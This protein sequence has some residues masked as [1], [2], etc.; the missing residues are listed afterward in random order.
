HRLARHRRQE[1]QAAGGEGHGGAPAPGERAVDRRGGQPGRAHQ[2]GLTL[3]PLQGQ[4]AGLHDHGRMTGPS[5]AI[6]HERFPEYGGSE[7]VVE[8]LHALWPDAPI[9]AAVVD[10]A[11]VPPGL[12]G[13]DIRPTRL[14]RLYRGG[15]AYSHLLP[16]IPRAMASLDLGGADLVVTSHHAFANRVRPR[17]GTPVISYTHTPARWLWEPSMRTSEVGGRAGTA[18]LGAF[19]ASQRRADAAAAARLRGVV[20][21]SH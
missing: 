6:V 1:Q 17:P 14:Q 16:F 7:Q 20:V 21:N 8:Q 4:G 13:A 12:Q 11:A 15:H 5:V 3:L 18:A 9:Y 2:Q 10:R 19:A